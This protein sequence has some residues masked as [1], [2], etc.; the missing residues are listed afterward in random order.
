MKSYSRAFALS[1][2]ILS[3]VF[4]LGML[5][6]YSKNTAPQ[7]SAKTQIIATHRPQQPVNDEKLALFLLIMSLVSVSLGVFFFKY[8]DELELYLRNYHRAK[9]I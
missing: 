5:F 2:I 3:A 6:Q 7:Q 4:C 9:K 1:W 8:S